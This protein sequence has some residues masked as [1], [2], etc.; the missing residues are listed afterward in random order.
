MGLKEFV[1]AIIREQLSEQYAVNEKTLYHGTIIDN[2]QSIEQKGLMPTIGDFVKKMYAGSVD[3]KTIVGETHIDVLENQEKRAKIIKAYLKPRAEINEDARLAIE[4]ADVILIGPGDLYTSIIPNILVDGVA[5]AIRE[6]K[7]KKIFVLNLMTKYGQT[8]GYSAVD[9]LATIEKYL[10]KGVIDFILVNSKMPTKKVLSWYEEY[11]EYPVTD[12]LKT[13]NN[14]EIIRKDLLK[15]VII[16]QNSNDS[17]KRSIIR[18]DGPTAHAEVNVIRAASKQ[19]GESD[20]FDYTLYSTLEPCQ[21]CLS[22]AAWAKI[23]YVYFGAYRKDVDPSLFDTKKSI[24]DE[25]E[26]TNMNLRE[27]VTMQ[28]HG[29][30]LENECAVLL[31]SYREKPRH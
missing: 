24:G 4:Q 16:S 20:L 14:F 13:S 19:L 29:G 9:H 17:L 2:L 25:A 18:H 22:A 1:A 12:D 10:G 5:Q 11:D 23:P 28:V 7:A 8:T 26:S 21:M 27:N 30:I 6:S 31:G 15:D 3:G